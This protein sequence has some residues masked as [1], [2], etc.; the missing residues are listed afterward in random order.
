MPRY[1]LELVTQ[2]INRFQIPYSPRANMQPAVVVA[3]FT[4]GWTL[5]CLYVNPAEPPFCKGFDDLAA[6]LE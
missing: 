3:R 1:T 2:S 5:A 6:A 4:N